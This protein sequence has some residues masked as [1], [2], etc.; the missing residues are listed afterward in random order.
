VEDLLMN[1]GQYQIQVHRTE[2]FQGLH[3]QIIHSLCFL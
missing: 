1:E 3:V 2:L